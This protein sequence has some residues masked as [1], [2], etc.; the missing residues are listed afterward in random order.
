MTM[1]HSWPVAVGGLGIL[2][3]RP[4]WFTFLPWVCC[5]FLMGRTE[6]LCYYLLLPPAMSVFLAM[7][8]CTLYRKSQQ[9]FLF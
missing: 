3:K 5:C 4:T 8:N 2:E 7:M 6:I 1:V 9:T